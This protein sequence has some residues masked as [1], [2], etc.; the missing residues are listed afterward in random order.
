[1]GSLSFSKKNKSQQGNSKIQELSGFQ[2][3]KEKVENM[4]PSETKIPF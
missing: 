3:C 4:N 1:M 2:V